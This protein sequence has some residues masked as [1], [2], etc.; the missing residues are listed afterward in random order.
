MIGLG[1]HSK[2]NVMLLRGLF[3][4]FKVPIWYRYDHQLGKKEYL[5]IIKKIESQ[6]KAF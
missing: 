6:G 2:V 4:N 5:D 3:A 1:P